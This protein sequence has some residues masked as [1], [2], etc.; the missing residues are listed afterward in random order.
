[1]PDNEATG[2]L[3][4]ISADI[5][6]LER[7]MERASG[8]VSQHSRRMV[9]D[10]S[11]VGGALNNIFSSGTSALVDSATSRLGV[12]G[13]AIGALGP[14]GIAA[15]AG[16]GV[17]FGAMQMLQQ[18][19]DWAD[20]LMSVANAL[21]MTAEQV[22]VLDEAA[23]S[24]GVPVEQMHAAIQ[25][26]SG[27]M[28]AMQTGIGSRRIASVFDQLGITQEQL[29]HIRDVN[30]LLPL[31]AEGLAN[32]GTEAERVQVTRRLGIEALLPLL[33]QGRDHFN[34]VTNSVANMGVVVSDTAVGSLADLH[35]SMRVADER[36]A[37]ASRTLQ[38]A[39]IPMVVA[40]K[41][42]LTGATTSLANFIRWMQHFDSVEYQGRQRVNQAVTAR[43]RAA[44][45]RRGGIDA[46]VQGGAAG[47][48]VL[49]GRS[50]LEQLAQQQ[51]AIANRIEAEIAIG[52]PT[53]SAGGGALPP[54][55]ITLPT[56]PD[57]SS[58]SPRA[59]RGA[60]ARTGPTAAR[61]GPTA[62][63]LADMR[64]ML[65]LEHA[66]AVAR[67]VGDNA[68]IERLQD[69]ITRRRDIAAY[70]RAGYT[71]TEATVQADQ[72]LADIQFARQALD[73]REINNVRGLVTVEERRV[74]LN[75]ILND[76][77]E[78]QAYWA[79]Q[80]LQFK[81]GAAE[82]AG[83]T[84]NAAATRREAERRRLAA[85]YESHGMSPEDAARRAAEV[86]NQQVEA[87]TRQSVY[88]AVRGGV[89]AAVRD[90]WRGLAE[91]MA[92]TLRERLMD[93]LA[94]VITNLIMSASSG[95]GT[96]S[97]I[98]GN[99]I[100]AF[101]SGGGGGF[102]IGKNALGT[103]NWRGGLSIVG[104]NGPELLNIPRGTEIIPS[105]A[106]RNMTAVGGS[107]VVLNDF[108]LHAEGAIMTGE[109]LAAFDR[110]IALASRSTLAVGAA[111]QAR[112]NK[113]RA[114]RV[115]G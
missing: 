53:H 20:N 26:L 112:N 102:K 99:I 65:G 6:S 42:A 86:V 60:A 62:Q 50:R 12:L 105:G 57:G 98:I 96:G 32:L 8:I 1:M 30:D 14:L 29:L 83:N 45:L 72:N 69:Q 107:S 79:E 58:G 73:A 76:L 113:Q 38:T 66:L 13:G 89:A 16:L 115:L 111:M 33:R 55:P 40:L 48:D 23:R 37:A 46:V 27:A 24:A 109:L 70:I 75:R 9:Q 71:L 15:G 3:L 108:H 101:T 81:I 77:A 7:Q 31:V 63:E 87:E 39:L 106:L 91:Y 100:G 103:N 22:Q 47:L 41:N 25:S 95:K 35:T 18:S 5:R 54:A 28:G 104:E 114:S 90:G 51:D 56:P 44:A 4:T 61:T 94:D 19:A 21:A 74:E 2:L 88:N 10:A 52:R 84:A 11:G 59:G 85:E 110:K 36:S 43:A 68:Q 80:E 97:S 17:A 34:E 93:R 78:E 92:N 49:R 82:A 67:E 64:E